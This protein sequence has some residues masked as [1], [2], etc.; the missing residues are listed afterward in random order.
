MKGLDAEQ[1]KMLLQIRSE[2]IQNSNPTSAAYGKVTSYIYLS[3]CAIENRFL[4]LVKA[5]FWLHV[6]PEDSGKVT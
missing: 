6:P 5:Y 1:T 2:F 4:L 3:L